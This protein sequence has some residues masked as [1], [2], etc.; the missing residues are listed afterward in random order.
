MLAFGRG[1]AKGQLQMELVCNRLWV[2]RWNRGLGLDLMR[3]NVQI[4]LAIPVFLIRNMGNTFCNITHENDLRSFV[5]SRSR[6]VGHEELT[7]REPLTSPAEAGVRTVMCHCDGNGTQ[8]E[9]AM[10]EAVS[11]ASLVSFLFIDNI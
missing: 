8:R 1:K 9:G 7:Y 4:P 11:Q 3:Y 6:E 2:L 5:V 10:F